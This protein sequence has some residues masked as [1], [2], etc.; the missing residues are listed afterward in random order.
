MEVR[1]CPT[2]VGA[3]TGRV[4]EISGAVYMSVSKSW[5]PIEGSGGGRKLITVVHADMVGY[6]R[7]I[8]L[9]DAGTLARLRA[10]RDTLIEPAIKQHGGRIVQTAGDSLLIV[11]DSIDGAARCAIKIQQQIPVHDGD[12]PRERRIRFR[13]GINIGD[14]II[15]GSDLHGDGVNVAARLQ[16]ECP[17]GGIC[18]SRAVRDH[19][20]DRLGHTFEAL[21]PLS[22]KNIARPVDA[23]VL[24][25]DQ[26][27]NSPDRP[28]NHPTTVFVPPPDK[29]TIAVLPFANMS[30]NPDHEYFS[31]GVADDIITELSRSRSL[32][33][34][35][36]N[37]SFTYKGSNVDIKQVAHELG[38]RYVVE[39]SVRRNG[40]RI[41]VTAQL[42]DAETGNHIW[43]ERYDRDLADVFAVQDEIT[44]AVAQAVGPAIADAEQQRAARK[45]PESLNAWDAYARGLWHL[46]RIDI[47]EN[48]KAR[49]LFERAIE[50]D[51]NFSHAYQGLVYTHLDKI[52]LLGKG[53]I[54]ETMRG[55]EALARRAVA[56]DPSDAKAHAALGWVLQTLG[57]P[58][59]AV[60]KAEQALALNNNCVEAFQLKGVSL[61]YLGRHR[62]GCEILMTHLRINPR[63]D[64]NWHAI[65]IIGMARYL[66]G[67]YEGTIDAAR[68]ALHE[69]PNQRLSYR[70]LVAA[71][72][73]LGR[74]F[75]A[76][77]IVHNLASTVPPAWFN[78]YWSFRWPWMREEDVANL[79]EGLR[80]V[81]G[82]NGLRERWWILDGARP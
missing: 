42:V 48:E 44:A 23:F 74:K 80:K 49:A 29:P 8:G 73:Q 6:S 77:T 37:S 32:F 70:W 18:V 46:A 52:R 66:F 68:R 53:R 75:E 41:R 25:L 14:A 67:D 12:H 3:A 57:D 64:R 62:D 15:D 45:P 1:H 34:T 30:N 58:Q 78:E 56:L 26:D 22:L 50:L 10:L 81:G 4:G 11:F 43:A 55:V 20:Q 13:V 9:D 19:V 16:A 51:P 5:D 36:R 72:G 2:S 54:D 82:E 27:R 63:D 7:L 40:G 60:D 28:L 17:P 59:A 21:G 61:V 69:N 39:G 47:V 76:Q 31:D 24:R 65:H 71:L 33:V 35:A 38:V 79:I